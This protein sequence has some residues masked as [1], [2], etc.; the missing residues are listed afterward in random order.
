ML[1]RELAEA[2]VQ[3]IREV[4]RVNLDEIDEEIDSEEENASFV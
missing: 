2:L 1:E 4:P 3:A